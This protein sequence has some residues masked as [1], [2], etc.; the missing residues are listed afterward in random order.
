MTEVIAP[1]NTVTFTVT[2]VP[3]GTAQRKTIVRLMQMQP[4]TQLGLKKRAR[5]RRQR[6]NIHNRHGGRPW[7]H[8]AKAAKLAKVERGETFTLT[9]TPQIIP[10]IK[11]VE[12]FLKAAKA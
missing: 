3:R 7:I 1:L 2:G 8:R 12:P 5:K 4:A 6:D 11:S 9:L 10:D